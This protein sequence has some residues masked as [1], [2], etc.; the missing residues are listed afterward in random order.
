MN[1]YLE[2]RG[3]GRDV[4]RKEAWETVLELHWV[5]VVVEN[6]ASA[7]DGSRQKKSERFCNAW[8]TIA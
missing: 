1:Q 5:K 8:S 3:E 2:E 4:Y 7:C 6:M